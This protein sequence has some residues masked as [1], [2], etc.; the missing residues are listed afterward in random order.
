MH[1]A[2]VKID[3]QEYRLVLTGE[4]TDRSCMLLLR[5]DGM[6]NT[7][8]NFLSHFFSRRMQVVHIIQG[9]GTRRKEIDLPLQ[10]VLRAVPAALST[11]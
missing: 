6:H 7:V 11:P 10:V 2:Q 3:A 5:Q 4:N 9:C 1:I 8:L